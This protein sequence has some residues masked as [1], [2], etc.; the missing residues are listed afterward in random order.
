[1]QRR[2]FIKLLGT[3][4]GSLPFLS[5]FAQSLP[6]QTW[7]DWL[8]QLV[9]ACPIEPVALSEIP[10][11]LPEFSSKEF[12][13]TDNQTYFYKQ[14]QYCFQVFEKTHPTAGV[15]ALL[16]P[17]WKR[18]ASGQWEKIACW[19]L[20]ELQ[21]VAQASQQLKEATFESLFPTE[22]STTANYQSTRGE[23]CLKTNLYAN[24]YVMT[25]IHLTNNSTK[26]WKSRPLS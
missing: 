24:N 1:M 17:F 3:S 2:P 15:L 7:S 8:S 10:T 5:G 19:S 12:L 18:Q 22:K 9:S 4:L 6:P 11:H 25:N 26:L 23:V 21:A 20:F 16:I 13:S 14:Q